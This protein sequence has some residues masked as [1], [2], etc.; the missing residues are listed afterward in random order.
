LKY[1]VVTK[2]WSD[3]QLVDAVKPKLV[4]PAYMK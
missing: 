1:R 4:P 2:L 3:F